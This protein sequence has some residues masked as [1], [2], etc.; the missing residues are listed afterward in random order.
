MYKRATACCPIVAPARTAISKFGHSLVKYETP[1][2]YH[3]PMRRLLDT[4]AI[5]EF[6]SNQLKFR[7]LETDYSAF[8]T[9][10]DWQERAQV[11]EDLVKTCNR[12]LKAGK[13]AKY[14]S[15]LLRI[16]LKHLGHEHLNTITTLEKLC[17]IKFPYPSNQNKWNFWPAIRHP[18]V[19]IAETYESN[20][21]PGDPRTI[22]ATLK[23]FT[24]TN[25]I[26]SLKSYYEKHSP[27]LSVEEH[28]QALAIVAS[29][30]HT[31]L[32]LGTPSSSSK[33]ASFIPYTRTQDK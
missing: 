10:D 29:N 12:I 32:Q 33:G 24:H 9:A 6:K 30:S 11:L 5:E 21:G 3:Q 13:A 15:I 26:A 25:D 23:E 1:S 8:T 20:F 2:C 22:L 4:T 7:Q 27:S 31:E 18:Y 14:L 17:D 28:L 19:A 16:Y